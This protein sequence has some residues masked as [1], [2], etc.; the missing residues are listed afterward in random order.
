MQFNIFEH[1]HSEIVSKLYRI[2][3][4]RSRVQLNWSNRNNLKRKNKKL[5]LFFY[6]FSSFK[7]ENNC[8]QSSWDLSGSGIKKTNEF[9]IHPFY[10]VIRIKSMHFDEPNKTKIVF[11]QRFTWKINER[12]QNM[13]YNKDTNNNKVHIMI[14]IMIILLSH[15]FRVPFV[16]C[17]YIDI[18]GE[19]KPWDEFHVLSSI[20]NCLQ[21]SIA[22]YYKVLYLKNTT[23]QKSI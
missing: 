17:K 2:T 10:K 6:L 14:H 11:A 3:S 7:T 19:K 13:Y 20:H 15:R 22:S 5:R 1:I 8:F 9:G 12:V 21:F 18:D 4:K 16:C 23:K